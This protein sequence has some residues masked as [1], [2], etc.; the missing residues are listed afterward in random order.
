MSRL[1]SPEST[2]AELINL[3]S[4]I[5]D[6]AHQIDVYKA[7]SGA[8]LGGGV[9]ILLLAAGAAYDLVSGKAGAWSMLGVTH[10]TLLAIAVVL[11]VGAI[12]LL[13]IGL[14]RAKRRDASLDV[15]LDQMEQEYAELLELKKRTR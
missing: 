9:F 8:A 2:D 1:E 14:L 11:S 10:Q 5:S 12:L 4:S 15:K 13:T 3:R 6:L 7:K